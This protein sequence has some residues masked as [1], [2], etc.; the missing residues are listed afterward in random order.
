MDN[1][2]RRKRIIV[3]WCCYTGTTGNW[4]YVRSVDVGTDIQPPPI[5]ASNSVCPQVCTPSSA[6][7]QLC[8]DMQHRAPLTQQA[9][10]KHSPS[11]REDQTPLK[12]GP[13]GGLVVWRLELRLRFAWSTPPRGAR[14][15]PRLLK[16][17][18]A[19]LAPLCALRLSQHCS[20]QA[21]LYNPGELE[22]GEWGTRHG[23]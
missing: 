7:L 16:R 18:G 5:P 23:Y 10:T 6:R 1:L 20:N 15:E 22:F 19:T 11:Q 13:P 14:L 4:S 21:S 12:A 3:N 2:I 8:A 17:Q 9:S